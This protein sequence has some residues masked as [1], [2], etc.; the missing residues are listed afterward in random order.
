MRLLLCVVALLSCFCWASASTLKSPFLGCEENA[1]P[2]NKS[3]SDSDSDHEAGVRT[4]RR[5]EAK[6]Y[7]GRAKRARRPPSRSPATSPDAAFPIAAPSTSADPAVTTPAAVPA[8]TTPAA[9]PSADPQATNSDDPDNPPAAT[10]AAT[11]GRR[12]DCAGSAFYRAAMSEC[13]FTFLLTCLRFDN[14]RT[15]AVRRDTD[16]LAPIRSVWDMFIGS[17]EKHFI[18][19]EYI[20]VDA[21]LLL[22]YRGIPYLGKQGTHARVGE[23]LGHTFT[24]DLTRPYHHTNRNVT[25]DN[26][27]TSVPL[28]QDLLHNCGMTLVGTVKGN[29]KEIPIMM[30]EKS[31]RVPGTSAFLFT[32][33]ISLV[34]Y[35]PDTATAKKTVLLMSS[36]HTQPSITGTGKPEMIDFYNKTKGGVDTFDQMCAQ[37]SCS[38]KTKRW[39]LAA[40]PQYTI[41]LDLPPAERWVQLITDKKE[42]MVALVAHVRN[43]TREVFGDWVFQTVLNNLEELTTTLPSPY[44]EEIEGISGASGLPAAEITLYNIFY[45]VFSFCTSVIVQDSTGRLYHGRNLDFGLFLGWN[46]NKGQQPKMD[47]WPEL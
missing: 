31:N 42:Q 17:C 15:R 47:R 43:L 22:A 39:P 4:G 8:V 21:C 30:K 11:R 41:N 1:F 26:W 45:E 40:V 2:P 14:M 12:R 19:H 25:V 13:R 28:I 9:G 16:K 35:V 29:K 38:R 27:F 34:S 37:Y 24:R 32:N 6:D 3:Q 7:R 23:N 46:P 5:R 36:M 10:P 20:T 44:R 33:D 18:P